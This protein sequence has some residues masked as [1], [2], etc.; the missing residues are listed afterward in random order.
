LRKDK[1]SV[2][3]AKKQRPGGIMGFFGRIKECLG[4][5]YGSNLVMFQVVYGAWRLSRVPRPFVS[6]FGGARLSQESPYAMKANRLAQ[7]LV[8][9]NVTVLTGGGP[10]VMHAANCG[11]IIP[12]NNGK[13]KSIGIGVSD[14]GEGVNPCVQ[15]Y[16]ELKYFFARKWLLTRYASAFV[17]FPGGF[18]TM[19][20]LSEVLTLFQ[21]R[22]MARVPIVLVGVEY[23]QPFITWVRAAVEADLISADELL[24]FTVTDDLEQTF[25]IVRDRCDDRVDN[26][27]K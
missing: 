4:I 16:F 24:F 17:V 21:T 22:K 11:A 20:E 23:W 12:K 1:R 7:R 13:G 2:V 15:E 10:G 18:G 6:I 27:K 8:E 26:K 9:E 3:C 5:L 14:L 25:C 19:D